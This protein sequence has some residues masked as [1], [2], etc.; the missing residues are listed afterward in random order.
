MPQVVTE[1]LLKAAFHNYLYGMI[2]IAVVLFIHGSCLLR[3]IA[4][5]ERQ[6]QRHQESKQYNLVFLNFYLCFVLIAGVHIL[7]ITA[8]GI[9][10]FI[11]GLVPDYP[12]A[13]LFAGSCYTTIGFL[14]DILPTTWQ[15]LAFF[16]S[17]SGLFTLAWTTSAMVSMM[18][19]NQQAWKL[20]YAQR[21][22]DKK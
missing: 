17:F 21:L 3:I 16:I 8:W 19:A 5:F 22:V 14:G 20:K 9:A 13:L 10:L 15:G 7:E 1:S 2:G 6:E 11:T 12:N 18:A 4:F